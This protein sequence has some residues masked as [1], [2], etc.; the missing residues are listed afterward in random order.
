MIIKGTDCA[1]INHDERGDCDGP[2]RLYVAAVHDR[3]PCGVRGNA[4]RMGDHVTLCGSHA[5]ML[6]RAIRRSA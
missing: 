1:E 4:A 6:G 3:V 2:L 5:R